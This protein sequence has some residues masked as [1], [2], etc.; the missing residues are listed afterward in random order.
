MPS[1]HS[2]SRCSTSPAIPIPRCPR[3]IVS[4]HCG[5]RTKARCCCGHGYSRRGRWRSPSRAATCPRVSPVASWASSASSASGSF[6]SPSPLRIPSSA[7]FPC[8]QTDATSTRCCRIRRSR[9]IRR[10]STWATWVCPWPLRS[11]APRCSKASS[12]RHGRAGRVHGRRQPGPFWVLASRSVA[13]GHTT[14]S[15]G[16]VTGSGIRWRT[17]RSCP[18]W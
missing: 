1:S 12:T 8:R 14:S 7:S 10:C 5:A 11:R 18:G 3:S 16:A 2:T 4:R 6:C 9:S 13:G 17:P 15:V